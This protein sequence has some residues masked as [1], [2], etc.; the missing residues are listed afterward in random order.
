[1]FLNYERDAMDDGE[2]VARFANATLQ[3]LPHDDH[4]RL[5]WLYAREGGAEYAVK[6][7]RE[8]LI[9]YTAARGSSAHF[10]ET[11]TWA[12][13]VLIADATLA[14]SAATFT[15]FLAEHPRFLRRDLLSGYYSEA[16]LASDEAR[17]TIVQPDLA[18]LLSPGRPSPAP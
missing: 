9:A 15:D 16:L 13:A 11:R 8:G 1:M 14:S 7:I 12:W 6:R 10:H 3:H 4:V 18:T 5:V 2:L 17:A